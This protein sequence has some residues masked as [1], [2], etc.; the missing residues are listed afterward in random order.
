M[1]FPRHDL[2]PFN[3]ERIAMDKVVAS[4]KEAVAD[5]QD[6]ATIAIAG[7]SVATASRTA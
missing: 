2:H 5:I 4:P 6:G 7:F 1:D 3:F